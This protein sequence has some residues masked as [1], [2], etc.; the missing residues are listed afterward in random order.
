MPQAAGL[1][2]ESHGPASAPPVILSPGLGGSAR[3]WEPNVEAFVDAGHRVIL[4]DHRG[5]GRSD[6][7]LQPDLSID[8]MADDLW[9]LIDCLGESNVTIVGHAL[10]GAI[11][12]CVA[13]RSPGLIEKIV[14]INGLARP[15]SHFHRCFEVR[16]A[17]LELGVAEFLRAQ[18]IFLYPAR[19]SSANAERLRAEEKS[20]LEHFQGEENVRARM[21]A[22]R[23]MD[24]A[25]RL[26]DIRVPVLLIVAEDD[27]LVPASCSEQLAKGLPNA[28]LERMSGGHACNV[29]DP[30]T[31]NRLVLEFL[32]S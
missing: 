20:Q 13:H 23:T 8:H 1:W 19:W 2:Y 5:T 25:G 15:D 10:G 21:A 30:A 29:T 14:S 24:I 17:L 18:P 26:A 4:Y 22:L 3:Y 27:M 11:A 28:R 9:T 32:R 16:L 31:F 6:R 7:A 12:L